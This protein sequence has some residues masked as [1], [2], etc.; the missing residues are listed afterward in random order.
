MRKNRFRIILTL[1]FLG[2]A[3]YFLYP[4]Y[5]DRQFNEEISKLTNSQDSAAFFDKF[6]TDVI[7]TREDRIKLGLDLQGGMYVIMEVDVAK[8]MLD[9]ANKQ[10]DVLKQVLADASETVKS[11]DDDFVELQE[12]EIFPGLNRLSMFES[13]NLM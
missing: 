4:T 1:L 3:F 6:G 11:S 13:P 2:L 9:I 7:K 8:L 10:D 12:V 5:K